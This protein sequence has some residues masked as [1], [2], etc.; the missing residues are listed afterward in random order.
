MFPKL[1]KEMGNEVVVLPFRISLYTII[2]SLLSH[3][4]EFCF[5]P[6]VGNLDFFHL[7]AHYIFPI[8]LNNVH[9]RDP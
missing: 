7:S 9:G 2:V 6:N 4:R 5:K 8:I 3:K 1:K